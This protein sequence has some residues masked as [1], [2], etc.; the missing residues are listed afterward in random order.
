MPPLRCL[1]TSTAPHLPTP[2]AQALT[3]TTSHIPL[4]LRLS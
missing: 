4:T 1:T 2:S 3:R